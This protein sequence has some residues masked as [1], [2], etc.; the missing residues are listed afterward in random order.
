M[1]PC[2]YNIHKVSRVIEKDSAYSGWERES[3]RHAPPQV[4]RWLLVQLARLLLLG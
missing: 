2:A 3:L 4:P 1:S